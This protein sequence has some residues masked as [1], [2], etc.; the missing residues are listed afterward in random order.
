MSLC[1][2][3]NIKPCN[4]DIR[5]SGMCDAC[6]QADCEAGQEQALVI[7][8]NMHKYGTIDKPSGEDDP[9]Y[10]IIAAAY[11]C[12][13]KFEEFTQELKRNGLEELSFETYAN[14][15]DQYEKSII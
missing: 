6:F 1:N 15:L 9:V 14:L 13:W 2:V 10:P 3:C 8:D 12:A 7:R 5:C 11:H 4:E